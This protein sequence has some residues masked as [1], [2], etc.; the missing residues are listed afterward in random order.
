MNKTTKGMLITAA[1]LC[2]VQTTHAAPLTIPTTFVANTPAVAAD[3]NAN[4]AAVKT[5]V[6]ANTTSTTTNATNITT[7][8]TN[9]TAN[10]SAIASLQ[11]R[12]TALEAVANSVNATNISQ[13]IVGTWAL[14]ST[15]FDISKPLGSTNTVILNREANRGTLTI[16]TGGTFT[17]NVT[18]GLSIGATLLNTQRCF[19]TAAAQV[20]QCGPTNPSTTVTLYDQ[21]I[22][23][24]DTNPTGTTYAGTITVGT[25]NALTLTTNTNPATIYNGHISL[26]GQMIIFESNDPTTHL[27]SI[28][29]LIKIQ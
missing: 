11:T 21:D 14:T 26:N 6:D 19:D 4:F 3:V 27:N 24:G 28:M 5:A 23:P 1:L 7:N 25:N 2:M 10:T 29:T 18:G 9:I 16:S 22:V 13:A 20:I 12:L 8:T 17:A 15:T